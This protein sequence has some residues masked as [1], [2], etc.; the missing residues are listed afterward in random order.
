MKVTSKRLRKVE[1]LEDSLDTDLQQ[2]CLI[3]EFSDSKDHSFNH[4]LFSQKK[5]IFGIFT[6]VKVDQ[7]IM[8]IF[9]FYKFIR[10]KFA[11]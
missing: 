9:S 4:T 2:P 7:K 1:S 10:R 8:A 3:S 6:R 11:L 5:T